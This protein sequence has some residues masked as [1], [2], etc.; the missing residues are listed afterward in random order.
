M[1]ISV[2]AYPDPAQVSANIKRLGALGLEVHVTEM[3]V[4]CTPPC[5][6]DRLA[7][8]ADVYA[9]ILGACLENANCKSFEFWGITDRHTWLWDFD[10]PKHLD[11]QPLPWDIDYNPKPAYSA[12]LAAL[13]K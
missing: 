3:D 9:A 4:R 1:H 7:L 8:Q 5:G 10:N 2:D 13:L 12:M 6:P 11:M